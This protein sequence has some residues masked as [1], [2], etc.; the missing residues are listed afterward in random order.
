[1]ELDL[2]Y[3]YLVWG[4]STNNYCQFVNSILPQVQGIRKEQ[5]FYV[6]FPVTFQSIVRLDSTRMRTFFNR[7]VYALFVFVQIRLKSEHFAC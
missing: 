2:Y 5:I 3:N 7:Q 6:R 4:L 1:M